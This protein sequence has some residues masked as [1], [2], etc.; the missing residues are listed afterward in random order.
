MPQ[1]FFT[2]PCWPSPSFSC[3]ASY[4][5]MAAP[6]AGRQEPGQRPDG[7]LQMH[8]EVHA[9]R[10]LGSSSAPGVPRTPL[11]CIFKFRHFSPWMK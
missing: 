1:R 11:D 7:R 9:L 6:G 10:A 2:D 5:D 3:Q 8:V 4:Q